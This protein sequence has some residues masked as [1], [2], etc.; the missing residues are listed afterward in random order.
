MLK[1]LNSKT[2]T[3]R[4]VV[5]TWNDDKS[6][7]S[8]SG[9]ATGG[10]AVNNMFL[11]TSG[12]FPFG[13]VPG[14]TY[15]L[16][17][18]A[19]N[20]KFQVLVYKNN[21][22]D[23]VIG[24]IVD[25]EITIPADASGVDI[26]LFVDSGVTASETVYPKLFTTYTTAEI[27]NELKNGNIVKPKGVV[28]TGTDIDDIVT[29]GC[30]VLDSANTY[31]HNPFPGI[32]SELLVFYASNNTKVQVAYSQSRNE[33][34]YR[35]SRLGVYP[36]DWYDQIPS[37]VTMQ[38][39]NAYDILAANYVL[40]RTSGTHNGITYTWDGDVCT[41]SGE[42]SNVSV[43]VLK[44]T[45]YLPEDVVPGETY[46]I[47]YTTTNPQVQLRIMWRD[48]SDTTLERTFATG[49]MPVTV[50]A[51]ATKWT[52]ALYVEDGVDLDEDV[53]VSGIALVST[54]TNKELA[55][56][57]GETGM[58]GQTYAASLLSWAVIGASFDSGEFNYKLTAYPT[59]EDAQAQ[60]NGF[61]YTPEIDDF[62]Y[63][64]W[65]MYKKMNG[66]SDLYIYAN[67]GQNAR[68]WIYPSGAS[69]ARKHVYDTDTEELATPNGYYDG[70]NV[71]HFYYVHDSA[72]GW[73]YNNGTYT[74]G[75]YIA[76]YRT[77]IG[78]GG[79][80]WAKM[81]SDYQ[82]GNVKQVFVINL[83]SND[84]NNNYPHNDD[85]SEKQSYDATKYYTCGEIE[86]IGTY[87]LET[88]TDTVPEGKTEGVVPGVV[89]SY[90]AYIGAILNRI[91]AIQPGALI[92]LCTIRKGFA[93]PANKAAVWTE[94][95]NMLK[96]IAADDRYKDNVIIIDNG[97]EGPDYG[98]APMTSMFVGYHP[99]AIG[100][101]YISRFWNTLIN[102]A[103]WANYTKPIVK[104]GMFIGTG[105]AFST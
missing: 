16:K 10:N 96:A 45:D 70:S 53:T 22:L 79:G 44:S 9:K 101:Q 49:D 37:T 52:I 62:R 13:I 72:D 61:T 48:N 26:R 25:R 104:Q 28:T 85:W 17:Y 90:A 43:N 2:G 6:A 76:P 55:A 34:K 54:M 97:A 95:N 87:D 66:I 92:L 77:G 58:T 38:K 27:E 39:F 8:V 86:D 69:E 32:I 18:S 56:R 51:S 19:T 88:D 59:L 20:V 65:D 78:H 83:G 36:E 103:L 11:R 75:G 67:G 46:Y 7:C 82:N 93:S 3:H 1:F 35:V 29:A 74:K 63:A 68:D 47:K 71:W 105:K 81:L 73:T 40:K 89:N 14:G 57:V 33:I 50:P 21:S 91:I 80:T 30:Y 24:S 23:T 84:I 12:S 94:Y 64:C 15:R 31:D 98:S 41:V 100:Y 4:D 5:F 42:A 102:N 60:T 99:N